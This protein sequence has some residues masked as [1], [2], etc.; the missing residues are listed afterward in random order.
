VKDYFNCLKIRWYLFSLAL[1]TCLNELLQFPKLLFAFNAPKLSI[2]RNQV[3]M[4]CYHFLGWLVLFLY[5]CQA[6][7]SW[8]MWC[9]AAFLPCWWLCL[10]IHLVSVHAKGIVLLFKYLGHTCIWFWG[11]IF[12]RWYQ[13]QLDQISCFYLWYF[14]KN[15]FFIDLFPLYWWWIHFC[16]C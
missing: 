15:L 5:L 4:L 1:F 7:W 2:H 9:V 16:F 14:V 12:W 10:G 3:W 6:G 11:G 8:R 13:S